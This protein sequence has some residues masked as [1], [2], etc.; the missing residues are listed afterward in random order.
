MTPDVSKKV[1]LQVTRL[2]RP[3][4]AS[5]LQWLLEHA[6]E[7]AAT[8]F[9]KRGRVEPMWIAISD[10]ARF[11]MTADSDDKDANV[12]AIKKFFAKERVKLY[13]FMDEA[14]MVDRTKSGPP[15]SST[16]FSDMDRKGLK[17]HPDRREIVALSG[18]DGQRIAL[19]MRYI[20]RPEHGKP[21]LTPLTFEF[22]E[23]G[24]LGG[25]MVGLLP[26]EKS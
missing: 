15:I 2:P 21:S 25:R 6:S 18:E 26:A 13:V 9:A 1:T 24:E 7:F 12:A 14:W 5:D 8:T 20:L 16:E 22:G 3:S 11:V 19:G 4:K 17:D 10:I 23:S